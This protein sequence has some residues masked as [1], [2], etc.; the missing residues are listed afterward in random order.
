MYFL[1]EEKCEYLYSSEKLKS[2]FCSV[3]YYHIGCKQSRQYKPEKE[4][5]SKKGTII[6]LVFFQACSVLSDLRGEG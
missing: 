2:A 5:P 3:E 4:N 1:V 6:Y